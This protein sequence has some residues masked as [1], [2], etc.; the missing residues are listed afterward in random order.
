MIDKVDVRVPSDAPYSR[1][2]NALYKEIR[3]DP[4]GPF[5]PGRHYL[6]S[7][8]LQQYGHPVILHTHCLHGKR[9]DHKL[10]L[11][12]T[13]KMA[14][15][16]M[17]QEITRVFNI[18]GEDLGLM[19]LDLAAD[20]PGVP[21]AWFEQHVRAKFKRWTADIG[22][23]DSEVQFATMGKRGVETVYFGRRPNVFRIYNKIAEFRAQYSQQ[24]ALLRRDGVNETDLP[25]FPETYG[26]PETGLV[27]TR[28]ERQIGAG[29]TLQQIGKFGNLRDLPFFNPF[30]ALVFIDVGKPQPNPD[31]YDFSTFA[32][33]MFVRQ[34]VHERG[35]HRAKQFLN[36]YSKR[37]TNRILK[38]VSD[39]L[40]SDEVLICS[41]KLLDIYKA[42]VSRQLAA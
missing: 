32:T 18:P 15:S 1:T 21:V 28:V 42:S 2:F 24:M 20:V 36:Q 22:K 33:G 8:D 11:I 23:Y 13:G 10:E 26:Y 4:K 19:R 40:P 41:E 14:Y 31:D 30:E 27:L 39:F 17:V 7:A 9:G 6:A 5:R 38:R 16:E 12:D 3:N 37:N 34:L 25:G 29:R 35:F